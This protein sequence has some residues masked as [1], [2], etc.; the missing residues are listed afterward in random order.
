MFWCVLVTNSNFRR[1]LEVIHKFKITGKL[2]NERAGGVTICG[3]FMTCNKYLSIYALVFRLFYLF[4]IFSLKNLA[5]IFRLVRSCHM[6]CPSRP[7]WVDQSL[8]YRL[9]V[10]SSVLKMEA[11][12]LVDTLVHFYQIKRRY[13]PEDRSLLLLYLV[14]YSAAH[15]SVLWAF[16]NPWMTRRLHTCS[17]AVLFPMDWVYYCHHLTFYSWIPFYFLS[18]PFPLFFLLISTTVRS[19]GIKKPSYSLHF[20]ASIKFRSWVPIGYQ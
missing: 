14:A 15:S 3:E 7:P 9:V 10:S 4:P 2:Q 13:I 16:L 6:P 1:R 17:S 12:G 11:V 18:R 5:R 20:R 19:R 8:T